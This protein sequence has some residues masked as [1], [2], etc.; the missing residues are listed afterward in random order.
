MLPTRVYPRIFAAISLAWDWWSSGSVW[1][2][3]L[4]PMLMPIIFMPSISPLHGAGSDKSISRGEK[5][6]NGSRD[7]VLI[8]LVI[9]VGYGS[10][11]LHCRPLSASHEPRSLTGV[12]EKICC[13]FLAH[14]AVVNF[15]NQKLS[16][17]TLESTPW[18]ES[19]YHFIFFI[20]FFCGFILRKNHFGVLFR[21]MGKMICITVFGPV[22]D[23]NTRK[24]TSP[25]YDG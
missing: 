13:E 18:G 6:V 22:I 9:F 20:F 2:P 10:W 19:P 5:V 3:V 15:W 8:V 12:G 11:L 4:F 23:K 7:V 24:Y 1:L 14:S 25:F 21:L 16:D 17:T